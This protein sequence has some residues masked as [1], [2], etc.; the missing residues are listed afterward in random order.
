MADSQSIITLNIG[1]QTVSMGM[2]S[3]SKDGGLILKKFETSTILADPSAEMTRLPQVRLAI[4]ELASRIGASKEQVNYA[5]SGQSI[6]TK[7]VKLPMLGNDNL[8]ELVAF[9]AQQQ[10]PFPMDEVVWDWHQLESAGGE[11]EV[12]IVA[13]KEDALNE[14]ND[15]VRGS[16]LATGKVDSSPMALA[17]AFKFSYG[18]SD[19]PTLLIDVGAKTSNLIYLEGKKV[20]TRSIAIGGAAVTAAIA[21]EYGV[22][23]NDAE[24]QKLANGLVALDT[25]HTSGMDELTGALSACIRTSLNRMPSEIARTTNFYRS[26]QGG[27]APKR[28]FIAGGGSNL[29]HLGDFLVE[30]MRLPVEFFNPLAKVSVGSGVN[31]EQVAT[32]AH[33]MGELVGLALRSLG[34]AP[35]AVDLVPSVVGAERDE[36]RR[37]PF[38]LGAAAITLAAFGTLYATTASK[39]DSAS[40]MSKTVEERIAGLKKF[41]GP[42]S[43]ELKKE[44]KIGQTASQYVEAHGNQRLWLD[45]ISETTTRFGD[46]HVWITDFSPVVNYTP[47]DQNVKQAVK[48][49]FAAQAYGITGLDSEKGGQPEFLSPGRPNPSYV[50]PVVNAIEISGLWRG[51]NGAARVN[52]LVEKLTADSEFYTL[53]V[54]DTSSKKPTM[55]KLKAAECIVE[56]ASSITAGNHAAPFKLIIPLKK[57]VHL[58]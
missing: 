4:S 54:E 22:S 24:S 20:F 13:I 36:K 39:A 32:Q 31:A 27:S 10:I 25:R 30:K 11:L 9:E 51:K 48:N 52:S 28:V 26:Q 5:L 2:F 55:R 14:L 40:K 46:T 47:G 21:K 19:E 34:K 7:F 49:D 38:I 41:S 6:V 17:N 56:N 16:G 37:R 53:E 12:V 58:K 45:L 8:D 33:Q 42:I 50:A 15:C 23:Y 29:K 1:S 18:E 3:P 57:T 44:A 35:I 43:S